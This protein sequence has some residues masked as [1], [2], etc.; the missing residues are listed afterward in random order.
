MAYLYATLRDKK[1]EVFKELFLNKANRIIGEE[2]LFEG[3]V[4]EAAIHPREVLRATI[5]HNA[6]AL[7]LVHN[8]PSGRTEPSA[9]DVPSPK[10][11]KPPQPPSPSKSSITSLLGIIDTLAFGNVIFCL[12]NA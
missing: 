10:N 8:H 2:D 5:A 9:E 4:D 3:T 7:I 12:N 1:R 11:S 6:T